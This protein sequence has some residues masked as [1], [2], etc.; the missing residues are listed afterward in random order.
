MKHFL[1]LPFII[2]NTLF[3]RSY[4]LQGSVNDVS[5]KEPLAYANIR[6][7]NSFRGTAANI[8]GDFLLKLS[9]G[10]Y[11]LI[12]SYIGYISD[13]VNVELNN[14]KNI[15]ISLSPIGFDL[16][17]ITVFPGENPAV[18]IIKNAISKK[19]LRK[20]ALNDYTFEAYTKTV[21]KTTKDI[22]TQR[23]SE[24]SLT[25]KDTGDLKITAL[26]ENES[27]GYFKNPDQ[28]KD[29][30]TARKQSKNLP[31]AANILAGGRVLVDFYNE[32]IDVVENPLVGPLADDALDFYYYYISDTL[33]ID[34]YNVFEISFEPDDNSDPGLLGKLYI[35]DKNF[36][37][38]KI[39]CGI[40]D[41]ANPMGLFDTLNITQQY[42]DY[43][44]GITLPVDYRLFAQ[45]NVL[46][47]A[48]F[49]FD[50]NS[51]FS[52]YD[53]NTN[54]S[55]DI[56]G[57]AV[58]TVKPD[59]DLKDSSYWKTA[60]S[61]PN[62]KDEIIAYTRIDSLESIPVTFWDRFSFLDN[63][64]RFGNNFYT[65]GLTD[66]YS[67]TRVEGHIAKFGLDYRKGLNERLYLRVRGSYGFSDKKFK[68]EFSGEYYIG[69]YR[70]SSV[71]IFAYDKLIPLFDESDN[72]GDFFST[73]MSLMLKEDFRDYYY[74]KGVGF[75]FASEV[76]P[77]L[78]LAL[79]YK[80]QEDVSAKNNSDFSFFKKDRTYPVNNPIVDAAFS[81]IRV[82]F[83]FDFRNYIE[84]GM[85]RNRISQGNSYAILRG[86]ITLVNDWI[87]NSDYNY[88]LYDLNLSGKIKT[89]RT[90]D[91]RFE[92]KGFA[93]NG[94]IPYQHMYALPGN[95]KSLGMQFS[96]RTLKLGEVF[97]DRV[98]SIGI[99]HDFKDELFRVLGFPLLKDI[100]FTFGLHANGAWVD[101]STES[102]TIIPVNFTTLK[103]P[104]FEAGFSIG[105]RD[106]PIQM[107]F[108]WRL[109]H[110]NDFNFTW[111][112]NIFEM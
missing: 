71:T 56:F 90:S 94:P 93:G 40:T 67:F 78:E 77:F 29:V 55:D 38:I 83:K 1:L 39:T 46:G 76:L 9:G 4:N 11:T 53:V 102:S 44:N 37:L 107:E 48:K 2:L 41:A 111:G 99:Q 58:L 64:I 60:E 87:T 18:Q 3:A 22:S 68:K 97:G 23:S 79:R 57:Y 6:V 61:I 101:I 32:S 100:G 28:Y 106:L 5:S 105:Q 50:L 112:L 21:L 16:P 91:L 85:R 33:A 62:T 13:T 75:G 74:S 70:T 63:E 65:S 52:S 66:I 98:L 31:P 59:A 17:P 27:K 54:L 103:N 42:S 43:G 96:F 86:G 89:F 8:E 7:E 84:D 36:D 30:I 47:L 88:E 24:Y 34:N 92:I 35:R 110:F 15:N 80:Y 20:K 73:L 95:I 25:R 14:D 10:N 108:T 81:S 109:N 51:V 19:E 72:Y 49:G 26:L 12:I 45:G 69:E 82:G 104:F